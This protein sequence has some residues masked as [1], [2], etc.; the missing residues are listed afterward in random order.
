MFIVERATLLVENP[1]VEDFSKPITEAMVSDL[2]I[3][4]V[5]AI[6][7]LIKAINSGRLTRNYTFYPAESLIGKNKTGNPTGYSS[8]VLPYGKPILTEH[9]SS[10]SQG[11]FGSTNAE[12]PIGRIIASGFRKYKEGVDPPRNAPHKSYIPGYLEGDGSMYV[13]AGVT[14]SDA[15]TRILGRAFHTVSIGSNVENV[16]ESI[17]GQNI[18]E[19]RRQGK[20]L[21]P[22][23]RG[24]LYEGKLSYW[25]MG[26]VTGR[27][28]SYVNIPSDEYAHTVNPDVGEEG[29]KLLL[30][31]KKLG[32]KEFSFFDAKT[33]EKVSVD[34]D[35]AAVDESYMI[36]S[37]QVNSYWFVSG[38]SK[39]VSVTESA[40]EVTMKIDNI[41]NLDELLELKKD[42][43]DF[44]DVLSETLKAQSPNEKTKSIVEA[45]LNDEFD[46]QV[47]DLEAFK[48]LQDKA[49]ELC[50]DFTWEAAYLAVNAYE[51]NI[52][53]PD[54]LVL[55][56]ELY[57]IEDLEGE[58]KL[59]TKSRDALPDSAFCG[60]GR[61]FPVADKAHAVAALRLIGRY[62]GDDKDKILACIKRK[63]KKFGVGS[64]NDNLVHYPIVIEDLDLS[65][66]TVSSKEDAV[67]LLESVDTISEA[68]SFTDEQK[69]SF[70]TFLEAYVE[71]ADALASDSPL[72]ECKDTSPVTLPI[73][74]F[75]DRF[76]ESQDQI[77]KYLVP[78]AGLVRKLKIDKET[79][80]SAEKAYSVFGTAV[81][82]KFIE[83][84]PTKTEEPVESAP[85]E[86]ITNPVAATETASEGA[87]NSR[88]TD[89]Y[90]Y[91][92]TRGSK[93]GVNKEKK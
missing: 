62:K 6:Y 91:T 61:S 37:C 10:D 21:P 48:A 35:Y 64:E 1:I 16:K 20:E 13:V 33:Q 57:N 60:P 51:G 11:L 2:K 14:E 29:I 26:D 49:V 55:L 39:G 41:K 5:R 32:K 25:V 56:S 67:A 92:A 88:K 47:E 59:S 9:R 74:Y 68:Y 75:V 42:N 93:K 87:K 45:L 65:F 3:S 89:W 28:C 73:S 7:P 15:I 58:S 4:G 27:E 77:K 38:E 52:S 40:N 44:L 84:L 17:S 82:N 22:Y 81:L 72:L 78:L 8:F 31:E 19:L 18:A 36:D 23:E 85:I 66:E 53:N 86:T 70:K 90:S 24:Q 50:E 71:D 30:A 76:K 79:F 83:N 54:D 43:E 12:P 69:E 34:L 63:A 80:D 46:Y